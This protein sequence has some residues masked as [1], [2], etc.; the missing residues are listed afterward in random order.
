MGMLAKKLV[1]MA[2]NLGFLAKE[3]PIDTDPLADIP[4][5][6]MQGRATRLPLTLFALSTCG[7]CK[8]GIQY[9]IDA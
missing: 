4:F 3:L 9:L 7:F 5:V 2:E 8:K 1:E 6:Q